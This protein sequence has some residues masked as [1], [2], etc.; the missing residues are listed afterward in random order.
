MTELY[1]IPNPSLPL[2]YV[3]GEEWVGCLFGG[4]CYMDILEDASSAWQTLAVTG[5]IDDEIIVL[6]PFITGDVLNELVQCSTASKFTIVTSLTAQSIHS[7]S[8]DLDVLKSLLEEN[9]SLL[10]CKGLHAKLMKR[11]VTVVLGSQNFTTGGRHN[12]EISIKTKLG[13]VAFDNLITIL[14]KVMANSRAINHSLIDELK[15]K[16]SEL[17]VDLISLNRHFHKLDAIISEM[18]ELNKFAYDTINENANNRFA[19]EKFANTHVICLTRTD[20][21][22]WFERENKRRETG[23]GPIFPS[24]DLTEFMRRDGSKIFLEKGRYYFCLDA[25]TLQAFY[26]KANKTRTTFIINSRDV[27]GYFDEDVDCRLKLVNPE[28]D[29]DKAN[30]ILEVS[31][32]DYE[33]E[34][35]TY[36]VLIIKYLFDG[37]ALRLLSQAIRYSTPSMDRTCSLKEFAKFNPVIPLLKPTDLYRSIFESFNDRAR[38][39]QRLHHIYEF[40]YFFELDA[41]EVS[42]SSEYERLS[43]F[44]FL[45]IRC[46]A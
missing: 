35:V 7:G 27:S 31:L 43:S 34:D 6:S 30:I 4:V 17:E 13:E 16:L 41:N 22:S 40:G 36:A 29:E 8:I 25:D 32:E 24:S 9:C 18:A 46:L 20:D 15:L 23:T 10:T 38:H 3:Q 44:Q 45:T 39:W 2:H 42:V 33:D 26:L 1:T 12:L 21:N 14:D 37:K 19:A 11:G 5:N 28:D